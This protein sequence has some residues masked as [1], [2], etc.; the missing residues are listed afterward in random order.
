LTILTVPEAFCLPRD[1]LKVG[2]L[3]EVVTGRVVDLTLLVLVFNELVAV[4]AVTD[5]VAVVV[6][7]MVSVKGNLVVVLPV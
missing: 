1:G 5:V 6:L 4:V 3:F 2:E 7:T